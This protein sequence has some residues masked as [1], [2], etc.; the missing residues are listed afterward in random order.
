[1]TFRKKIHPIAIPSLHGT[2]TSPCIS[3]ASNA[4]PWWG[5]GICTKLAQLPRAKVTSRA[6]GLMICPAKI[7]GM[8]GKWSANMGIFSCKNRAIWWATRNIFASKIPRWCL[9]CKG[10]IFF[11]QQ[12]RI[13]GIYGGDKWP[14]RSKQG[15]TQV[16][17]LKKY[18]DQI[19]TMS[20]FQESREFYSTK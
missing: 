12:V 7:L 17:G 20:E 5:D 2:E 8:W 13:Y 10:W 1:M 16:L 11:H 3:C 19:H 18:V 9:T 4:T 15:L 6:M 14:I